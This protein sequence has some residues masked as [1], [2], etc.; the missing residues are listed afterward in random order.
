MLPPTRAKQDPLT[1][2]EER[3]LLAGTEKRHLR[4]NVAIRLMLQLGLRLNEA[5]CLTWGDLIDLDSSA[6]TVLIPRATAKRAWPR[7]LPLPP[8][9]HSFLLR[10]RKDLKLDPPL[11]FPSTWP[12]VISRHGVPPSRRYIQNTLRLESLALLGRAVRCHTLRHTFAT[13]LL[14]K[15]NL[16]V[17]QQALGHRSIKSTEIYTHPNISDL[18]RALEAKE[19]QQ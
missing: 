12:L 1:A 9:L 19:A 13:R 3:A 16:R 5:R 7:T 15:T 17:V 18:R 10:L 11:E 14:E 6:P 8:S 2:D 4:V